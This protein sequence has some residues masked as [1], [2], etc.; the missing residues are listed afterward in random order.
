MSKYKVGLFALGQTLVSL[1]SK[2]LS[3]ATNAVM[4]V[5]SFA[6]IIAGAGIAGLAVYLIVKQEI[7]KAIEYLVE[8]REGK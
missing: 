7:D 4:Q 6:M 5:G 1:G 8:K 3:G 2:V